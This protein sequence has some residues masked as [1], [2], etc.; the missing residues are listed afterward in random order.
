MAGR[1][2]SYALLLLLNIVF[3]LLLTSKHLKESF[4][5]IARTGDF[6]HSSG[7]LDHLRKK[8]INA[9]SFDFSAKGHFAISRSPESPS[10]MLPTLSP[11]LISWVAKR[12]HVDEFPF[13]DNEVAN[14]AD[15]TFMKLQNF[16]DCIRKS[17]GY[18]ELGPSKLRYANQRCILEAFSGLE[19]LL[20]QR[21]VDEV[22]YGGV[23]FG[24]NVLE[25]NNVHWVRA[26]RVHGGGWFF[27]RRGWTEDDQ[28]Y[29]IDRYTQ[30][31]PA[32]IAQPNLCTTTKQHQTTPSNNRPRYSASSND[33]HPK[34]RCR[35]RPP[36]RSL[37]SPVQ[38]TQAKATTITLA[39]CFYRNTTSIS[40][41]QTTATTT[42]TTPLLTTTHGPT[43]IVTFAPP[44][45]TIPI[46][47]GNRFRDWIEHKCRGL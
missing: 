5:T 9:P 24:E 20:D 14:L 1:R 12:A 30:Q 15:A 31:P 11:R 4:S 22:G 2:C 23:G 41:E 44:H 40:A 35:P 18:N 13:Y 8:R 37:L 26:G 16:N 42:I 32:H 33:F 28:Q 27:F 25:E 36:P 47:S 19:K 3:G 29:R 43:P 34:D 10:A 6:S 38:L 7:T 21:G 39:A 46:G 45:T 17:V